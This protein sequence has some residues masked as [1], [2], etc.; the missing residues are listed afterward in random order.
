[1]TDTLEDI[2][3]VLAGDEPDWMQ[4][5][6]IEHPYEVERMLRWH[7]IK[8]RKIRD[9]DEAFAAEVARL[10]Q[11]RDEVTGPLRNAA[12]NLERALTSYHQARYEEAEAW[13]R[14]D[15]KTLKLNNGTLVSRAGSE[16][17]EC[18]N[19]DEKLVDAVRSIDPGLVIVKETISKSDLKQLIARDRIRIEDGALINPDTGEVIPGATFIQKP[20]T[21]DVKKETSR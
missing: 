1:M 11:R 20:R 10:E 4:P 8:Q 6:T 9:Y 15:L 13:E 16:V 3:E 18:D 14:D 21:Y 12:A 19:S 7:A 17:I 5:V 2:D